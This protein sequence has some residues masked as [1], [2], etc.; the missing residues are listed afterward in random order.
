MN[1]RQQPTDNVKIGSF[2]ITCKEEGLKDEMYI[3]QSIRYPDDWDITCYDTLAK[4]LWELL[5]F[6]K[7]K[8]EIQAEKIK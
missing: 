6:E 2:K 4:A 5:C 7:V 1:T 3:R 8:R